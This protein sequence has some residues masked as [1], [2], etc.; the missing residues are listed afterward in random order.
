MP[1]QLPVIHSWINLSRLLRR[2]RGPP[3]MKSIILSTAHKGSATT[4]YAL[5]IQTTTS[6]S[7][8]NVRFVRR[9]A[10]ATPSQICSGNFEGM[11]QPL[12]TM[13]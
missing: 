4:S 13:S 12:L 6:P 10:N 8:E 11:A 2:R 1:W 3:S 7:S 9:R 5:I